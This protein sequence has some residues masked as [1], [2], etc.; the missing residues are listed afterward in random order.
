MEVAILTGLQASGKTS[1]FDQVLARTH[2]RVSK[3]AF[4]RARN[5]QRRQM[6]LLAEALDGGLDVAVD[7][8]NPSPEEWQPIIELAREHG[9]RVVGY[10]FPVD[11]AG[12]LERNAAR[13]GKTRV[14]DV[15]LYAT[16]KRLRRPHLVNGFD[17]LF[18]VRF[19][20]RG[21]FDVR[22]VSEEI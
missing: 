16:V 17:A 21:G 14:P 5:R 13:E 11:L 3:D 20:G 10:W 7:N 19:D 4:A 1:F 9:A 18:V 15:G 8:T 12:S 22:P 6:R 2:Q